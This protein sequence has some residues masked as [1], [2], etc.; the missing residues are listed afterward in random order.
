MSD[1]TNLRYGRLDHISVVHG[2]PL[3]AARF[4]RD[5]LSGHVVDA[6]LA[7]EIASASGG[8]NRCERVA[9]G[10]ATFQFMLPCDELPGSKE[11]FDAKGAQIYSYCIAVDDV[12]SAAK[13]MQENGA[14]LVAESTPDAPLSLE[15]VYGDG[16]TQSYAM[17][18]ATEKCGLRFEFIHKGAKAPCE[19]GVRYP[20]QVGVFQHAEIVVPDAEAA[21]EFMCTVMG[22]ERTEKQIYDTITAHNAGTVHV[23]YG[24]IVYQL[25]EPHPNLLGWKEHM[26]AIGP[27]TRLICFHFR[28]DLQPILDKMTARGAEPI[29]HPVVEGVDNATG[30]NEAPTTL[31]VAD[32]GTFGWMY[33]E[34]GDDFDRPW[35]FMW[36]DGIESCGINWEMLEQS[37]RWISSTGY[38]FNRE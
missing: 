28:N 29:R 19:T 23:L 33:G 10:G 5:S 11:F 2:D 12:A 30:A 15:K 38:F 36:L 17:L 31:P 22:A 35:K 20:E 27:S 6:D 4:V 24:G 1:Y 25:I 7:F 37:Y 18:D 16:K 14:K 9:T 21:A 34:D 3:N 32:T 8:D 26:E 13:R